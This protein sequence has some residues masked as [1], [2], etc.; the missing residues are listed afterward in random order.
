MGVFRLVLIDLISEGHE[1]PSKSCSWLLFHNDVV[2]DIIKDLS[3][4][5]R[6]DGIVG[7][8][9]TPYSC[10]RCRQSSNLLATRVRNRIKDLPKY[11]KA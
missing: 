3:L 6:F 11:S 9:F 4:L 10:S 8:H 1:N 2:K 5:D 7:K